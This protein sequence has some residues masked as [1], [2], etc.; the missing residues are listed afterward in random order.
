MYFVQLVVPPVTEL[1]VPQD[2][3]KHE[4][5]GKERTMR[6]AFLRNIRSCANVQI[7]RLDMCGVFPPDTKIVMLSFIQGAYVF[8]N[9]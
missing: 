8:V 6:P 7:E 3:L 4:E 2:T 9:S 1:M 5:I